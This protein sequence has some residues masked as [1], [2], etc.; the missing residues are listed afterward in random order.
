MGELGGRLCQRAGQA[1]HSRLRGLKSHGIPQA[2]TCSGSAAGQCG[3]SAG[4]LCRPSVRGPVRID[5]DNLFDDDD[6]S[7]RGHPIEALT[8]FCSMVILMS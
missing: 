4:Y 7:L 3:S 8:E 2:E 6:I 1:H 5:F